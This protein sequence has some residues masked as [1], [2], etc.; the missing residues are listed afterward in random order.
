MPARLTR[1]VKIFWPGPFSKRRNFSASAAETMPLPTQKSFSLSTKSDHRPGWLMMKP[2]R[3][4]GDRRDHRDQAQA[5]IEGGGMRHEFFHKQAMDEFAGICRGQTGS[6]KQKVQ[7]LKMGWPGDF[8]KFWR[9]GEHIKYE[10]D[11]FFFMFR[12]GDI[13]G[14]RV[15][16]HAAGSEC[17]AAVWQGCAGDLLRFHAA[18]IQS[19]YPGFF[20]LWRHAGPQP[21]SDRRLDDGRLAE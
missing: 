9:V 10:D 13:A 11:V 3:P 19:Q 6:E 12:H 21:A 17:A 16:E 1:A 18:S 4:R 20:R 8:D 14:L 15:P 7:V 2:R 5:K